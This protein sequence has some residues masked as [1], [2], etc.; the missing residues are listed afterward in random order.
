M[1]R[2]CVVYSSPFVPVEWIAAHGLAPVRLCAADAAANAPVPA[3]EGICQ[4]MRRF[5]NA[6]CRTD[7]AAIVLTTT[8]DQMRRAPDLFAERTEIP[9]FLMNVPATWQQ[10]ASHRTFRLELKRLGRFFQSLGGT[11]SSLPDVMRAYDE[12][13]S[14]LRALRGIVSARSFAKA[15][16]TLQATGRAPTDLAPATPPADSKPIALVGGPLGAHAFCLF[17]LIAQYRGEVVLDGTETGER[18]LPRAFDRRRLCQDPLA[19]LADAYFGSIPDVFRR[20]NSE[21]YRWL[22]AGI[23]ARRA[24]GVLVVRHVWCDLWHAEVQ[25]MRELLDIPVVDLDLGSDD[26]DPM[27]R[28]RT[29]VQAFLE[30]VR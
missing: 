20:P 28:S 19:E 27:E 29:R 23:R 17:D 11:P 15:I 1:S 13:R 22:R 8:C 26:R 12:Q 9:V 7:A 16:A 2:R 14:A 30:A 21:L 6:A 25:R 4:Y 5:V 18:T 3:G 24:R 10:A